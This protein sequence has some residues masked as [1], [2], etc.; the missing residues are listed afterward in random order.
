MTWV[1]GTLLPALPQIVQAVWSDEQHKAFT[2][3]LHFAWLKGVPGRADLPDGH[4][5]AR[6]VLADVLTAGRLYVLDRGSAKFPLRHQIMLAQSACVCRVRHNRV[7]A[8]T[9][10]RTLDVAAH[11]MGIVRDQGGRLGGKWKQDELPECLR[12]VQVDGDPRTQPPARGT[13]PSTLLI[14]TD[15]REVSAP[16]IALLSRYRWQVALFFRFFQHVLNCRHL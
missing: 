8:V 10:V 13:E 15:L 14:A 6:D 1:D 9:A 12:L 7:F 16:V 11:R 2:L 4:D 5:D 3:H